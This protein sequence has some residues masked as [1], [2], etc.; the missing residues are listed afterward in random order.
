[1]CEHGLISSNQRVNNKISSRVILGLVPEP[2]VKLLTGACNRQITE[3]HLEMAWWSQCW[4]GPRG[5]I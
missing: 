3:S 2:G 4:V 1:M 5:R